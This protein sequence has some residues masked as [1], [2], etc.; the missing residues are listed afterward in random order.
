MKNAL[1]GTIAIGIG[2][3]TYLSFFIGD[4]YVNATDW[5]DQTEQRFRKLSLQEGSAEIEIVFHHTATRDDLTAKEL[6]EITNDRFGLGCSYAISIHPNGKVIQMN[7]F[8]EHTP[9]V[10]GMNSKVIS[11]AFVGNY[12]ENELPEIMLERACQIYKAFTAYD[13]DND[14]FKIKRFGVHKDYRNT[15]CPGKYV[16]EALKK[17]GI[18]N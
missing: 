4:D 18:I 3:V 1:R 10:G 12:E 15:A 11:I 8:E 6:C 5:I 13:E 17:E 7:D 16:V 2:L 14:D 9:S